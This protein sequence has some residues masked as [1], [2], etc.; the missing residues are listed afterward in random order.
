[1]NVVDWSPVATHVAAFLV[2]LV[3]PVLVWHYS[4]FARTTRVAADTARRLCRGVNEIRGALKLVLTAAKATSDST[5]DLYARLLRADSTIEALD[6][7]DQG[8]FSLRDD[9][10][11]D[12]IEACIG[13]VAGRVRSGYTDLIPMLNRGELTRHESIGRK[14]LEELIHAIGD[15]DIPACTRL[16]AMLGERSSWVG[17]ARHRIATHRRGK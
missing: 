3:A 7:S 13:A 1:V 10:L 8:L 15:A 4:D 9:R 11:Q 2:G 17:C 5:V 14:E 12:E 6:F 16:I